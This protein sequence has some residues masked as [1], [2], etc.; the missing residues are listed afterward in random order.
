MVAKRE[1]TIL[2]ILIPVALLF[3]AVTLIAVSRVTWTEVSIHLTGGM[4]TPDGRI[5]DTGDII[6]EGEIRQ[7]GDSGGVF[8]PSRISV[9]DILDLEF[10]ASNDSG[11]FSFLFNP[12]S[13]CQEIYGQFY[14]PETFNTNSLCIFYN[15]EKDVCALQLGWGRYKS[16]VFVGTAQ[17]N[18]DYAAVLNADFSFLVPDES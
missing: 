15:A 5:F 18:D 16:Y 4:M 11:V 10:S 3:V 2:G 14:D 13:N 8:Y 7:S 12:S 1:K 9:F 17:E 6:L